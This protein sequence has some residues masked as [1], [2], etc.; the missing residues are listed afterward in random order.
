MRLRL[1]SYGDKLYPNPPRVVISGE[2]SH[3]DQQ[4]DTRQEK[5]ADLIIH[6][7]EEL[8]GYFINTDTGSTGDDT[9]AAFGT[10]RGMKLDDTTN[11]FF[12]ERDWFMSKFNARVNS[13][14]W[15]IGVV[16]DSQDTERGVSVE[17]E[18]FVAEIKTLGTE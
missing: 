3:M 2:D 5:A 10:G 12:S 17:M 4:R 15:R 14:S 1:L 6:P 9:D 13:K 7:D 16:D 11:C 8:L 18:S